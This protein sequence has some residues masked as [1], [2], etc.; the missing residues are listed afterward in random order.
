MHMRLASPL[1]V[2][3]LG[4]GASGVLLATHLLRDPYADVRVTLV[5]KRDRV[6]QGIAYSTRNK[7]HVLNVNALGMSA[8]P[9]DR[10][11]FWRWLRQSDLAAIEDPYSFPPRFTYGAYLESLLEEAGK[12]GERNRLTIV[13]AASHEVSE[14]SNGV[15][16]RLDNGTSIVGHVAVLAVGHEERHIRGRGLAVRAG[17]EADTPLDPHARVMILGSGLSMVDAWLSL[18]GSYHRGPILVVSRHGLL[19]RSHKQTVPISIDA[20]DVPFGTDLSYFAN[21]FMDLVRETVEKGGD[22][23]S[24]VDGLRPFNQRVWQSWS[25][26]TRRRFLDHLRPLWNIHRHRLPPRLY[27]LLQHAVENGQITL[28]A[29]QFLSVT[30]AQE[31]GVVATIRRRGHSQA[32]ELEVARVYDCGGVAVNVEDSSNPV[33]RSL[34]SRGLGRPDPLR[35]GLDVT[36]DCA[37]VNRDGH[38][39]KRLFA[40]GPLTRSTFFEIES[41]PEIRLQAQALARHLHAEARG[42]R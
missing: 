42:V 2:I 16:V 25:L 10:E 41:V 28:I 9:D 5:E 34:V 31:G 40:I 21:W 33:I 24:V 3:I 36:T 38:A 23:R 20:A 29:G 30:E 35:I 6:G 22:W 26:R 11:H 18:A 4:G 12:S 7:D 32:E 27:D 15:E 19:P 37:L 1:S 8:F 17:T 13:H 14:T 39:S